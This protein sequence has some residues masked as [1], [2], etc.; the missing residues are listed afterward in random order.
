VSWFYQL[1][2]AVLPPPSGLPDWAAR[3]A[4]FDEA[5]RACQRPDWLVWLAATTVRNDEERRDIV[6]G[7]CLLAEKDGIVAHMFRLAPRPLERA[8][9][10]AS[11]RPL[12][13]IDV[14]MTDWFHGILFAAVVV[15]PLA[16]IMVVH[17]PNPGAPRSIFLS[18]LITIPIAVALTVIGYIVCRRIRVRAARRSPPL[19]FATALATALAALQQRV[20]SQPPDRQASD[21]RTFQL[22]MESVYRN[23]RPGSLPPR[24][25]GD[26]SRSAFNE[27]MSAWPP[28]IV[29]HG[30]DRR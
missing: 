30:F 15:V 12:D 17:S 26:A 4:T 3:H 25:A 8:H 13:D 1:K 11:S 29:G 16:V 18:D 21:A 23:S 14:L 24:P 5:W 22:R 28:S 19:D 20:E 9:L 2:A 6:A 7:A 10:W 27:L